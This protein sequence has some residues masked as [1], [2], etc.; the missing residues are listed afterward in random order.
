[1]LISRGSNV[2]ARDKAGCLPLHYAAEGQLSN[3]HLAKLI[4]TSTTL[5]S[6]CAEPQL[7]PVS[8]LTKLSEPSA[9]LLPG[10]QAGAI[11]QLISHKANIHTKNDVGDSALHTAAAQGSLAAIQALLAQVFS[12][13]LP[14]RR[15]ANVTQAWLPGEPS[16]CPC[17]MCGMHTF[18]SVHSCNV[19]ILARYFNQ[20]LFLDVHSFADVAE[21][22]HGRNSRQSPCLQGADP[23]ASNDQEQTPLYKAVEAKQAACAQ[24]LCQAGPHAVNKADEW[25]LCPLH[26][27][28]RAGDVDIVTLL[29]LA[30]VRTAYGHSTLTAGCRIITRALLAFT[31]WTLV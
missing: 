22:T 16:A 1:M 7:W 3:Q 25:G 30:Q 28:A 10:N 27:A 13:Y 6:E 2:A 9:L 11:M 17:S 20:Q 5:L 23:S 31:F 4:K 29:L 15:H 19:H 24:I 21:P 8:V 12:A 14:S 26:I 18:T